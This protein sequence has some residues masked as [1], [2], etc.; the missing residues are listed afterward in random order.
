MERNAG[1]AVWLAVLLFASSN[2]VSSQ[3]SPSV[4]GSSATRSISQLPRLVKFSGTLK[5]VEGSPLSGMI[6][7]TFALYSGQTGGLSLW[8]ERQTVQPDKVAHY[9]VILGSTKPEG[10]LVDLFVTEQAQWL[11]V[12][13]QGQ[14]EQRRVLL[15]T[16]PY[17]LKAVDAQTVGG[18]PPSAFVLAAASSSPN[19][20]ESAFSSAHVSVDLHSQARSVPTVTPSSESFPATR[21]PD[22]H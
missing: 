2:L 19:G 15:W 3:Q 6:D 21:N 8:L 16:V 4:G 13:P 17:A 7:V 11:G 18:L 20:E 5:A 10:L 14:A 12:Q 22:P 1:W 9:T